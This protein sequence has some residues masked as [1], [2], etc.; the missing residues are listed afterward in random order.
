MSL[1]QNRISPRAKP[2]SQEVRISAVDEP[3]KFD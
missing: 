2:S 3:G 1:A